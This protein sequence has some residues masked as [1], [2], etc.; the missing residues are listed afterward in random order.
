MNTT[1]KKKRQSNFVTWPSVTQFT[2][3]F[4]KK[5]GKQQKTKQKKHLMSEICSET[6][7]DMHITYSITVHT[8]MVRLCVNACKSE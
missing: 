8:C 6:G 1:K 5:S 2:K 3:I 4:T 7:H